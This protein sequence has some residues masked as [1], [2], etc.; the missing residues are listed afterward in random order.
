MDNNI[1][2]TEQRDRK[3]KNKEVGRHRDT[4]TKIG[5]GPVT[6]KKIGGVQK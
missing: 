1:R 2:H 3:Y 4:E 6:E 5:T